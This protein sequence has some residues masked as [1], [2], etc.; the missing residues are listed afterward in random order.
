MR[1]VVTHQ[2]SF[3]KKKEGSAF[4]KRENSAH[5]TLIDLMLVVHRVKNSEKCSSSDVW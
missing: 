2:Y 5:L 1:L 4:Q 3:Y